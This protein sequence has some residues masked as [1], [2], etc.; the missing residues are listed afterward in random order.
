MTAL[1][2]KAAPIL[3]ILL[4]VGG[5][6]FWLYRRGRE[7]AQGEIHAKNAETASKQLDAAA[8]RPRGRDELSERLRGGS[9]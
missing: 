7:A 8:D 5:A 4:A 3:L 9:F 2:L 1:A 6:A